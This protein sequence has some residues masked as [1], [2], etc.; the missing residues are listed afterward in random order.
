[1]K[2]TRL[3][4]GYRIRLSDSEFRAVS[5]LISLGEAYMEGMSDEERDETERDMGKA[6][7]AKVT[8][9]GSWAIDDDR[10]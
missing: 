8:G 10:R 2:I 4:T 3:K 7:L 6:A 1:M 5:S 9:N